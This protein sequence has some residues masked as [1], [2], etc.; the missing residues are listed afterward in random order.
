MRKIYNLKK[1]KKT[2]YL[3]VD[4]KRGNNYC[5]LWL[6]RVSLIIEICHW[7]I[8]W[9]FHK[10]NIQLLL[11]YYFVKVYR[12]WF[13]IIEHECWWFVCV[14]V[15]VW[16]QYT[17]WILALADGFIH[18]KLRVTE[19]RCRLYLV[20]HITC[21][22]ITCLKHSLPREREYIIFG[23]PG[24]TLTSN[25]LLSS[26]KISFPFFFFFLYLLLTYWHQNNDDK[27]LGDLDK[28]FVTFYQ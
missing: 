6:L 3:F 9:Y 28:I 14:C 22:I 1:K 27:N 8:V 7:D 25:Y 19:W 23:I 16:M 12:V 24:D 2:S 20:F 21:I 4:I 5:L 17:S 11:I 18:Y 26:T 15:C 10:Y 13:W